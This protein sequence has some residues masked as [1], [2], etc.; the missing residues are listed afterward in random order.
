MNYNK[1]LLYFSTTLAILEA[2]TPS[3]A[4]DSD[5]DKIS[6]AGTRHT[7][8]ETFGDE[9]LK[10][11]D[12][13][14]PR[15][16]TVLS[17]T[18]SLDKVKQCNELLNF[19]QPYMASSAELEP[20]HTEVNDAL[21]ATLT[22]LYSSMFQVKGLTLR[23]LVSNYTDPR[24]EDI[25]S[26]SRAVKCLKKSYDLSRQYRSLLEETSIC[27][28]NYTEALLSLAKGSS[29]YAE[30][31]TDSTKKTSAY[32][33]S[34]ETFRTLCQLKD[35]ADVRKE[36]YLGIERAVVEGSGLYYQIVSTNIFQEP[37]SIEKY[38]R[39]TQNITLL[40]NLLPLFER[41][42]ADAPGW[43]VEEERSSQQTNG[44]GKRKGKIAAPAAKKVSFLDPEDCVP[45]I[46]STYCGMLKAASNTISQLPTNNTMLA[47]VYQKKGKELLE[48]ALRTYKEKVYKG[49]YAN[50]PQKVDSFISA[51]VEAL[52][53]NEEPIKDFYRTL[54]QD[55]QERQRQAIV[56]RIKVEQ[57][58]RQIQEEREHQRAEEDVQEKKA[59][60][61]SS[62]LRTGTATITIPTTLELQG[63]DNQPEEKYKVTEPRVKPKTHGTPSRTSPT[64]TQRGEIF[65]INKQTIILEKNNYRIFQS[66]TGEIY[67]K[68]ITLKEVLH[69][70]E[71]DFK[72]TLS[73]AGGSHNKATAPNNKMWTIP[74]PWD[75]PIPGYYHG[76]LMD[77]LLYGMGIV[78]GELEVQERLTF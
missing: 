65:T 13:A 71:E 58:E 27:L 59:R 30:K 25:D 70:L 74:R 53:G 43:T 37:E 6:Y 56:S 66:L 22:S 14:Q 50:N 26:L 20:Q 9:K 48:Y 12:T 61:N 55:Y 60:L 51:R 54:R 31:E 19:F 18:D 36:C 7:S 41:G 16:L 69:L 29:L 5:E 76:Q 78:S 35:T 75:G 17:M 57:A 4:M 32:L 11:I 47:S 52:A 72:C 24:P 2:F 64:E 49:E 46:A 39:L 67:D 33:T 45:V 34:V 77:F 15:L 73:L 21:S 3:Y 42:L 62:E 63:F 10:A 44:K 23:N 8:L 1:S 28:N 68:H 38:K 40:E